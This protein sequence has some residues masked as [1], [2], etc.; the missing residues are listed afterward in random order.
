MRSD[1]CPAQ[2]LVGKLCQDALD[3]Q[4]STSLALIPPLN[5]HFYSASLNHQANPS[6]IAS[7][8]DK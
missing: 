7:C 3:R 1:G 8:C 6:T 2:L 5:H 4:F